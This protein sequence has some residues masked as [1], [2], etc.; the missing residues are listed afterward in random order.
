MLCS[1]ESERRRT[2]SIQCTAYGGIS[3]SD[4][5]SSSSSLTS[6]GNA[7]TNSSREAMVVWTICCS[8][9][10]GGERRRQ[11]EKEN[12]ARCRSLVLVV[13]PSRPLLGCRDNRSLALSLSPTSTLDPPPNN[14]SDE[15]STPYDCD[16]DSVLVSSLSLSLSL[17]PRTLIVAT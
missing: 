10:C 15:E 12:E 6:G 14:M 9:R 7:A 1:H 17:S 4:E 3:K 13:A 11:R 16:E 5:S 8:D 2:V